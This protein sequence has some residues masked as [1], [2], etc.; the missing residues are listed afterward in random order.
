MGDFWII[1]NR[2][3]TTPSAFILLPNEVRERAHAAKRMAKSHTGFSLR[4]M[5]K[6]F[7]VRPGSALGEAETSFMNLT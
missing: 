7:F 5:T 2:I 6:M 4:I 1:V 3:A